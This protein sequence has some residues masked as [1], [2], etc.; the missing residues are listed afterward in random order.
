VP[1]TKLRQQRVDGADLNAATT[2]SV[3]EI[4]G[5]DV[6]AAIGGDQRQR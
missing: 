3:S 1:Q 4:G 6:V 2:T 5:T